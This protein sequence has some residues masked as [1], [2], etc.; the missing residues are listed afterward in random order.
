MKKYFT[1][2]VLFCSFIVNAQ[3]LH[4]SLVVQQQDQWCWAGC[5]KCILNYYGDSVNQCDIAE[6][7][8]TVATWH[9]FGSTNCCI[10]AS[11]GCNYWNYN[12]G[13]AGSIKDI[14]NH[15][16]NIATADLGTLTTND[17]ATQLSANHLF[18]E[19]WSWPTGGGHFVV[20][21][22]ISGT[23]SSA[24]IYYMNPWPGEG[25][26][27][28]TY[29]WMLTGTNDMGDHTWDATNEVTS[30]PHT[31]GIEQLPQMLVNDMV[32]PNPSTGAVWINGNTNDE[33]EI[34][35]VAGKKV[36]NASLKNKIT[37]LEL[38]NLPKGMYIVKIKS[39][40][41]S[42]VAKLLLQ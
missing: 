15:F 12:W 6:Y 41:G 32:Y 1:I 29:D 19:H 34:F 23:G 31:A 9:S 26:S 24:S 10:N 40:E 33:V 28:C 11:A 2:I 27:V 14:L 36:Y 38:A 20:G 21:Y 42:N 17:I 30:Y 4:V 5:S 35:N 39:N 8:R 37:E 25:L 18:V 7:T 22:G 16:D 13:Y 3:V